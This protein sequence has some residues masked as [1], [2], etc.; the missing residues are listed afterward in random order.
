MAMK[1]GICSMWGDRLDG[2][3]EEVR[4]AADLG[5]ELI[6]VGDSPAGWHELYVSLTL[7]ALD[8]PK[9]T[10]APLVTSPF[11][12]HPLV[13][14]SALSTIDDLSGGRVALGLATGGSTVLAIGRP[15]ATQKEIRAELAALR[16]LFAGR[17][18]ELN[19]A[20]IKP[21]RFARPIPIYYSAFGPKALA[22]AGEQADGVI[23]FAGERHLDA[24]K[25][26]IDTVRA[27]AQ[28][29]GRDPL[30]IDIWVV[31][32]A[33]IRPSRDQAIDDLKA[34]IVVNGMA[35]RTPE[36][37][38]RV[39]TQF[40]GKIDELHARYDPT[41]HVVVGGRNVALM[42]ELGL[43]GFLA[44]FDTLAGPVDAATDMLRQLEAMG[45]STFIAALP[46]HAAPLET[47]RGL[48]LARSAM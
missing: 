41:E 1:L 27:A 13:T 17:P 25:D 45:V 43:T 34:F 3:R 14:A 28:A 33:S 26:R 31:S 2:F 30:S 10:L 40:R 42:E 48:A 5:F 8:A 38:A 22:L 21:L 29:A 18:A 23:L 24:L 15:P 39:P 36:T 12:R 16:D 6:T 44:D 4:L 35:F 11:M 47:I 37:L 32:F 19:G 20:E 9:A 7:A 46:G